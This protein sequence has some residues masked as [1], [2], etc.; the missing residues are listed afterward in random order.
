MHRL[1]LPRL[2][3]TME[4][5]RLD[6]WLIE[7]RVNFAAGAALYDVET[8]KVTASVE[9]TRPGRL[10]RILVGPD[11]SVAVGELL[12]VVADPGEDV[13][14]ADIDAFLS[15]GAA[16]PPA[17]TAAPGALSPAPV[18]PAG[19]TAL[20][21]TTVTR[22][23]PRTR[24]LAREL[25]VDIATVTATGPEG[26]VLEYDVTAA[27]A[28]PAVAT[29]A[30]ATVA[31]VPVADLA[32][33][34]NVLER[35]PLSAVHRRMAQA[36]A[37]SWSV[38]PQFTQM[39]DVDV[40]GWQKR[41]A[42]WQ[43]G[44]DV[45]LTFTDLVLDAVVR[46]ATSVPEVNSRFAGDHL[47]IYREVNVALAVDTPNGLFVPVLKGLR[48]LSVSGRARQRDEVTTRAREGRL[49]VD[50]LAGG[51][52]TVSNLGGFGVQSGTPLL[53]EPYTAIVFVGS[54]TERVVARQGGLAIR[55]ICTVS[56]AFDHRTVD[57]VTAARFTSA[58]AQALEC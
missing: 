9:A 22:A 55:S 23:M 49:T 21:A 34:E 30:A 17:E 44:S 5:G 25:G 56:N 3:Q 35:R 40:T 13:T 16:A 50:D 4:E 32:A 15:G 36:V 51:S 8:E 7:P 26:R 37:R 42:G 53:V 47:D 10:V 31:A 57:G 27:A 11:S 6:A 45:R 39:V 46:A 52:I 20:S 18:A 43:Q 54:I 24:A 29:P 2:G 14:E 19:A 41:R 58:L 33:D 38:V 28:A 48:E 12:A 1:S